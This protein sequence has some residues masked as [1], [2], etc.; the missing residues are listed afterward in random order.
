MMHLKFDYEK[1]YEALVERAG[2]FEKVNF[3]EEVPKILDA[4]ADAML[5]SM[6]KTVSKHKR[7]GRAYAALKRGP[8][9]QAGNYFSVSVG[10]PDI[11]RED[12]AGFHIVYHEH[13]SPGHMPA[14]RATGKSRYRRKGGKAGVLKATPFLKKAM[15]IGKKLSVEL[16]KGMIENEVKKLG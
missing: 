2:S 4:C 9:E 5:E 15:S 13:G 12:I 16:A 1:I 8:V 14:R 3:D 10:S 11:R 7:K 6:Q